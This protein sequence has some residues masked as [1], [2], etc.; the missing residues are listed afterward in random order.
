MLSYSLV[1]QLRRDLEQAEDAMA[2]VTT[3]FAVTEDKT[4]SRYVFNLTVR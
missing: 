2:K 3:P 4:Q 1:F